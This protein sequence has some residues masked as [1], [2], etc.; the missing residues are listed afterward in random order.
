VEYE[1]NWLEHED[2]I[3][4]VPENTPT[5]WISP[6]V[7][8]PISKTIKFV[9]ALICMCAANTAIKRTRH[10]TPTLESDSMELNLKEL[11]FLQA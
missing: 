11:V 7:S 3:E 8:I 6:V 4:K 1:I 9:C 2:I 5:E 10:P